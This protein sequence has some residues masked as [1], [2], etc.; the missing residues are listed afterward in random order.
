[1][2]FQNFRVPLLLSISLVAALS[3]PNTSFAKEKTATVSYDPY[4]KTKVISG[5]VHSHNALFDLDKWD[6][7]LNASIVNGI[8]K[9]PMLLFSSYTPEWYFFERAADID[10]IEFQVIKGNRDLEYI[11]GVHEV[12]GVE[13]SPKYL[14]D[15]RATG[16]NIKIIGSRGAKVLVIPAEVVST[17][18]VTYKNEVEKVGGFRE[19]LVA[20]QSAIAPTLGQNVQA[21]SS[22]A[23]YAAAHGG[24]GISFVSIPQGIY[25]T[26]V[27]PNSRADRGHLKPGQLITGINNKSIA[28]MAQAEVIALLKDATGQITLSVAGIGDIVVAP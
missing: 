25:L 17:F 27:A 4:Q 13:L 5:Q 11:G 7:W 2:N 28:G 12:I 15:H 6:Y 23:D 14:A 10:G 1:M 3:L 16:M 9:N 21:A 19:D 8:A 26:A 22:A 20:A 24:Y 18:E